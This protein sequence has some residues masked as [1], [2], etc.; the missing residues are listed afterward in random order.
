MRAG[1]QSIC[2]LRPSK[3]QIKHLMLPL[4]NEL[5]P[6]IVSIIDCTEI[7][8]QCPSSLCNHSVCYSSYKSHNT[9][10]ALVGVISFA[11]DLYSGSITDQEIVQR[12]RYLKH[13]RNVDLVM[14]DQ[15]FTIQDD[16]VLVGASPLIPKFLKSTYQFLKAENQ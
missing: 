5:Y 4:F 12:S 2:I 3:E 9:M 8:M 14:A 13:M 11:S 6:K 10:K 15:E 7:T 1:L 16:L